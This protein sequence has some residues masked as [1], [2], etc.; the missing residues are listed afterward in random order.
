MRQLA[1]FYG[2]SFLTIALMDAE[3]IFSQHSVKIT[4]MFLKPAPGNKNVTFEVQRSQF[5]VQG[6]G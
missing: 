5:K 1:E 6:Y 2:L 4:L 3:S